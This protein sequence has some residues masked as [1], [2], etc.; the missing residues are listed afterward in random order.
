MSLRT[1]DYVNGISSLTYCFIFILIGLIITSKYFKLKDTNFIFIGLGL[2]GVSEP[3]LSSGIS[4]LWNLFTGEGLSLEIYTLIGVIFI[5][6]SILFWM[7]GITDMTNPDKKK[8]I[9]IIYIIIGIIFEIVFL[10]LLFNAPNLIG[11]FSAESAIVHIDIEYKTFI[12]GYLL[13]V[14]LSTLIS[15]IIFAKNSFNAADPVVQLKGKLLLIG[16]IIWTV[17]AILDGF[18][19]L[20]IFSLPITRLFLTSSSFLFYLGFIMPP[21]IKEKLLK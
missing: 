20:N 4:F 12:L 21:K 11:T 19:P 14:I 2:M 6:F 3:W 10:F 7:M 9:T 17:G 5:P 13:F 8:L 18:I 16:V 15:T 1:I